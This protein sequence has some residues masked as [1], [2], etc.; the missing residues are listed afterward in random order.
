MDSFLFADSGH[1]TFLVKLNLIFLVNNCHPEFILV[2]LPTN[3]K[4]TSYF[5]SFSFLSHPH[6][7]TALPFLLSNLYTSESQ[8]SVT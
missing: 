1:D 8:F 6:A 5:Q 3:N 7:Q 2:L 4:N